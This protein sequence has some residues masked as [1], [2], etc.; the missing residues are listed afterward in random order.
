MKRFLR[1]LGFFSALGAIAWAM[2]DRFISLTVPR[3][4]EPPSF[5]PPPVPHAPSKADAPPAPATA[6]TAADDLTAVDGVGP[7]YAARLADAGIT[8]FAGLAALSEDELSEILG[9]RLS[10]IPEILA[11]A[12]RR[13]QG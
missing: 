6:D 3:E 12:T 11:D 10:R 7:V 4:P 2:R 5:R 1:L 13:A 8:T 9:S